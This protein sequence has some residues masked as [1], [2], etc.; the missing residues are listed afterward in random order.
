MPVN[1]TA[2]VDYNLTVI[3]NTSV[4][5]VQNTTTFTVNPE[6]DIWINEPW[7]EQRFDF[8][9]NIS[10]NLT[11]LNYS[12]V[13]SITYV[14]DGG[15]PIAVGITGSPIITT[16][17]GP[18]SNGNHTIQAF[19]EV[20]AQNFSSNIVTFNVSAELGS[21]TSEPLPL[22]GSTYSTN[23]IDVGYVVTGNTSRIINVTAEVYH[24]YGAYYNTYY[25]SDQTTFSGTFFLGLSDYDNYYVII[26]VTTQWGIFNSFTSVGNVSFTYSPGEYLTI[27]NPSNGMTL[28]NHTIPLIFIY[29]NATTIDHFKYF[30]NGA[31]S[32]NIYSNTSFTVPANG[33]YTIFM[34]GYY[35]NASI[36]KESATIS[37]EVIQEEGNVDVTLPV[38][39]TTLSAAGINANNSLINVV[40][41][42]T[43][44][45]IPGD[46]YCIVSGPAFRNVTINPLSPNSSL[47]D[48][49]FLPN[50]NYTIQAYMRT[51]ASYPSY[52]MSPLINFN[53]DYENGT[54]A[55]VQP[56]SPQLSRANIPLAVNINTLASIISREFRWTGPSS[57]GI[58]WTSTT[59]PTT[60]TVSY[61]GAHTVYVRVRT[62]RGWLNTS[63][64]FNV[65]QTLVIDAYANGVPVLTGAVLDTS[66]I[67][68]MVHAHDTTPIDTPNVQV[69]FTDITQGMFLGS[70]VTN[71]SGG[72]SIV[73]SSATLQTMWTGVH[74]IQ[75]STNTSLVNYTYF[76]IN[77]A[78]SV[79]ITSLTPA[80][81]SEHYIVRNGPSTY[82]TVFTLQGW[83]HNSSGAPIPNAWVQ[84]NIDG[85]TN[86]ANLLPVI[87]N[88]LT[89]ASGDFTWSGRIDSTVD[90]DLHSLSGNFI[91]ILHR[92][93]YNFT[94][95]TTLFASIGANITVNTSITVD[96]N[97]KTVEVFTN[98]NITGTLTFDNGTAFAGQNINITVEIWDG[99]FLN[100]TTSYIVSTNA[101]G[102]FEQLHYIDQFQ[103]GDTIKIYANFY[104]PTPI[105]LDSTAYQEG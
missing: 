94:G 102:D 67:T 17:P 97:P 40:Y 100:Y 76:A 39:G 53:V 45:I 62:T 82:G 15:A 9:S 11:Y 50:G 81:G 57:S 38:N 79:G 89:N 65:N 19:M 27:L 80:N 18:L 72:A 41:T 71:S 70:G 98:I 43:T 52:L 13:T 68:L 7:E 101:F 75:V 37:F 31:P 84:A 83:V 47:L 87:R 55:I 14:L 58:P 5:V 21:V 90:E 59:F 73:L 33:N 92:D 95:F 54:I 6:E 20:N 32:S 88:V 35:A 16:I 3:C 10:L 85:G 49:S 30:L 1:L 74:K 104:S 99:G 103:S 78:L 4:G 60:F 29:N 105:Y 22:N 8:Q 77:R 66:S 24:W 34:R 48:P 69:N 56:T 36:W 46:L 42:N 51:I 63:R 2:S 96:F 25:L 23:V 61:N 28:Y 12:A 86:C 64:A 93:G 44:P 26:N 91:G